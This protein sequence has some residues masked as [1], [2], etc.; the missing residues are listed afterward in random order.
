MDSSGA[1]CGRATRAAT[2]GGGAAEAAEGDGGSAVVGGAAG[3]PTSTS[4]LDATTPPPPPPLKKCRGGPSLLQLRKN[5]PALPAT[6]DDEFLD[7]AA[8]ALANTSSVELA[9][10]KSL[11]PGKQNGSGGFGE[12]QPAQTTRCRSPVARQ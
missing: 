6:R 10:Q 2:A 7:A 5:S 4:E 3:T 11:F 9:S 12:W 1:F 8:A